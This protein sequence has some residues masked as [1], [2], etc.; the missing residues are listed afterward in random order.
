MHGSICHK[1]AGMELI[2]EWLAVIAV[3]F[4]LFFTGHFL[5]LQP[6]QAVAAQ[7]DLYGEVQMAPMDIKGAVC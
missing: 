3:S 4:L 5:L 6:V 7:K 1:M 2:K